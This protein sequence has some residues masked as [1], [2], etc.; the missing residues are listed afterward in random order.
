[1][2]SQSNECVRAAPVASVYMCFCLTDSEVGS[3]SGP[4]S[5]LCSEVG[6]GN[7][8]DHESRR[9]TDSGSSRAASL[10]VSSAA[11]TSGPAGV[12]SGPAGVTSGPA[13]GAGVGA[14]AGA[15]GGGDLKSSTGGWIMVSAVAEQPPGVLR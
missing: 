13:G 9:T 12:T 4:D 6:S 15:G 14:T 10:E 3:S 7:E 5:G 11:V 1:M 2:C 8:A